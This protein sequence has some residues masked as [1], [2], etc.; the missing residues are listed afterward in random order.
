MPLVQVGDVRLQVAIAGHG[1]PLVL[2]HGFTGSAA[3]WAPQSAV[4]AEHF[5]TVAIDLLGHGG[6]DAPADPA[7]YRLERCVADLAALLDALDV[8][9]AC[10]L[11]YSMGARVALAWALT[12]PE[13]VDALVL[14]GVS[15]GI[16]DPEERRQRVVHDEALADEIEHDGVE[17]FVDAWMRQPLF[18]SQARLEPDTLAAARAARCA[19]R[20][21]G[22][23]NSLRGMGTGAQ[24][25]LWSR[26]PGLTVPT[27]L[28]VGSEDAKFRA[29]AETMLRRVPG[30]TIAIIPESGHAAHLENASAF[31]ACVLGFLQGH[32]QDR[33]RGRNEAA[34]QSRNLRI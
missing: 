33:A 10:W 34:T 7:R 9:R 14:E 21:V 26:L 30:A 5:R 25:S 2:L 20:P 11:G 28:A 6:S 23:A 1:A 19:N 22:L 15:P 24:Q 29:I 16:E 13:R 8:Q 12:Y 17:A 31:N 3:Q 18:A 32:R 27:L 4:F